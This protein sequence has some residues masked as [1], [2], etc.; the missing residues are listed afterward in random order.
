MLGTSTGGNLISAFEAV[1]FIPPTGVFSEQPWGSLAL[2]RRLLRP[3]RSWHPPKVLSEAML[4]LWSPTLRNYPLTHKEA[5]FT[6]GAN[7]L[8]KL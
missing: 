4:R 5:P 3:F 6:H 8:Q 1:T 2:E 7:S